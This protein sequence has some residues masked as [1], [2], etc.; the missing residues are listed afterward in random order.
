MVIDIKQIGNGGAFNTKDTNSSFL[1]NLNE[2]LLLFDCGY[3]VFKKLRKL[4]KKGDIDLKQLKHVYVSHLDDDHVGSLKSLMYY[5]YF[6][7]KITLNILFDK[8][9]Y[10]ELNNY[11]NFKKINNHTI[12][13]NYK[14]ITPKQKIVK[15]IKIKKN[16]LNL[17]IDETFIIKLT[18]FGT[19]HHK[20]CYGLKFDCKN[21]SFAITGDTIATKKIEKVCKSCDFIFHDF[22]KWNKPSEQVHAC[23]DNINEVY[24]KKFIKK[25]KFYHNDEKYN[26]KWINIYNLIK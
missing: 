26:K 17:K 5:Q 16:R 19:K 8:N 7:N 3:S 21:H 11:I 15:P 12:K 13:K 18:T 14:Y 23:E 20:D 25:L 9:I 10:K 2:S 6:V 24:S 1:I 4:D 22:S